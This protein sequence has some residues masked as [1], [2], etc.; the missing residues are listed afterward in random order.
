MPSFFA[1]AASI[2]DS[3][4]LTEDFDEPQPVLCELCCNTHGSRWTGAHEG[5]W[6]CE[7]CSWEY[8]HSHYGEAG[9]W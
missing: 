4:V 8:E 3:D 5:L 7:D 2:V 1:I 6:A 9:R